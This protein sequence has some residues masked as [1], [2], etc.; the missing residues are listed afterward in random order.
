M[1]QELVDLAS[2]G[3]LRKVLSTLHSNGAKCYFVGGCVRDAILGE[4]ITDLDLEVF[5]ISSD[6]LS[7]ILAK[8]HDIDYVGKSFG[9]IKIHGL[10]MDI[11]V[12]RTEEK[13]GETHRTFSI[14]ERTDMDIAMAASRRDFTINAL[15][16]DLLSNQVID[17]FDGLKDIKN[18]L[19]RHTSDKF[20]E[21]PLRVL[22]AM[23]FTARFDMTVAEETIEI[24]RGLSCD[25]ISC[26]RI[27][28][29][30]KKLLLLGKT[31]SRGLRFLKACGWLRYF[32]E[33]S[34]LVGCEQDPILHPEGDVF[35]HVC[36]AMDYFPRVR[37]GD[38]FDDM[39][40]GFALL[41]HDFGKPA[42][43]FRDK[44]GI[45][46]HGHAKCGVA[47]ARVFL[48]RMR[49]PKRIVDQVL[50]LVEHHMD[51]RD[52]V[53]SNDMDTDIR[54]L[55][56][57][58]ERIDLLIKVSLCDTFRR[59]KIHGTNEELI[60]DRAKKLGVLY[61]KPTPLLLGRHLIDLGLVPGK[62]FSQLLDLAFEAQLNGKFFDEPGAI[63]FIKGFI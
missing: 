31:P 48:E 39:V 57:Q 28:G 54:V 50:H 56:T 26:E 33:V 13:I 20:A 45:H 9:V 35:E 30:W 43:M 63:Q 22:R 11:S 7:S 4:P 25:N 23:Q 14:V 62:N 21:D 1:L 16:F 55:A 49:V 15:Y 61:E 42:T 27:L 47:P 53:K 12:P 59:V 52:I 60:Q 6:V 8:D 34:N 24:S 51:I 58:V 38:V 5:N 44:N 36:L 10:D 18:K 2:T 19:L 40:V 46:N 41:C 3:K 17:R 37:S 29:E 32:P